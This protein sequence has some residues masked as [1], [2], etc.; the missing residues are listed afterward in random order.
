MTEK[1]KVGIVGCGNISGRYIENSEQFDNF[2]I[3]SCADIDM[4]KAEEIGTKYNIPFTTV[5]ALMADPD[6]EIIL[7]LTNPSAHALVAMGALNAGKSV[8]NEKPLAIEREDAQAMLDLAK[9][10]GTRI[11]CAP[12]TFMGAGLSTCRQAI[13]DGLIG[14][15]IGGTAFMLSHGME[16]WHPNPEPFYKRGAGPLF[17]IGPYYLTAL[18]SLVGP[19][20]QVAAMTAIPTPERLIT[21]E[22]LNGTKIKVET[23]TT[24]HALLDFQNGVTATLIN[25]FDVWKHNLPRIE[26]YGTEGT[27]SVP[28]PNTFGGD[29]RVW[30]KATDQWEDLPLV[31]QI[32]DRGRGIGLSDMVDGML[33]D[34]PHQ[35]SGE[36]AYHVLDAMHAILE[37]GETGRYVALKSNLV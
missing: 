8:Y 1:M 19:I 34:R 6:I 13:V 5:D 32:S 30:R 4:A 9:E 37:A 16:M 36:L 21:S 29:V 11:G 33:H 25:S 24:V 2:E 18:V 27:L 12:D 26:I 17:D 3:A 7:N 20:K 31:D 35:A 28:D 10:K 22:P 15:P 23:P 14:E